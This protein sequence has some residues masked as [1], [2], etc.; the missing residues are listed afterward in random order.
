MLAC[1]T[2]LVAKLGINLGRTSPLGV[3]VARP[4]L[5][6]VGS[7][8]RGAWDGSATGASGLP[9]C[10]ERQGSFLLERL[11]RG[12]A[13]THELLGP[14]S[15]LLFDLRGSKPRTKGLPHV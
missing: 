2:S 4:M 8:S 7:S 9:S 5:S 1:T 13:Q 6:R 15:I 10:L 3:R 12:L 11:C 14:L